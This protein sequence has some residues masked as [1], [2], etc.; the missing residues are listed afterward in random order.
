MMIQLLIIYIYRHEPGDGGVD[1]SGWF[2]ERYI[3]IQCK[4]LSNIS[5]IYF[6]YI[7]EIKFLSIL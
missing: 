1:L 4:V 2:R 6:N 7:S 3:M 5:T